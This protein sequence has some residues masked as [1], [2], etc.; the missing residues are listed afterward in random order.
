MLQIKNISKRYGTGAAAQQA[1]DRVSLDLRDSEFVSI[2]GASGSGKT[3]LLN[4][5]GGLGGYDS[6]DI[7][8]D[9]VS[10]KKYKDRDW[11]DYR[12]HRIGFVF[13]SYHLIPHQSVL[14]NVELA[15]TIAGLSHRERKIRAVRALEKVGLADQ[16]H[17]K[18]NQLSGGQMQRVAIARA[19]VNEPSILLADEPTGA[20]DSVTSIQIM[21][22]LKQISDNRLVVM[23]THNPDL[24]E[25]YSTRIIRL[26]D[27]RVLDDSAPFDAAAER[28]RRNANKN[29]ASVQIGRKKAGGGGRKAGMSFL[30]ALSLSF[31]N[32]MNK[33]GR[34]L[35]TAFAG[36]IGIIGI[37][38]VLAVSA[39]INDYID[40]M[41]ESTLKGYPISITESAAETTALQNAVQEGRREK[42]KGEKE[43]VRTDTSS[44]ENKVSQTVVK[45]DL[46]SFKSFLEKKGNGIASAAENIL[47]GYNTVYSVWSQA[48]DGTIVPSNAPT[49]ALIQDPASFGQTFEMGMGAMNF[50]D[51]LNGTASG[52]TNFSEITP[53]ADDRISSDVRKNYEVVYGS[54]PASYDEVVLVLNRRN[55]IDAET[56]YQLGMITGE[57]LQEMSAELRNSQDV[58]IPVRSYEEV[59]SHT[60]TL[61][62]GSREYAENTGITLRIAGLV[63][64]VEDAENPSISTA[65]A[66]TSELTDWLV[67]ETGLSREEPDSIRIYTNS[68]E[69]REKVVDLI[70]QYNDD[71]GEEKQILYTDYA[72]LLTST[73]TSMVDII[74]WILV[75]LMAVSLIVSSI[76][77]A[78]IT[79]ISV[80]ERTK[81]IGIL[82]ALGASKRNISNVFNAETLIIGFCAGVIGILAVL[83]LSHPLTGLAVKMLEIDNIRIFLPLGSAGL[84]VLLSMLI[85]VVAGLV[86]ARRAAKQDPVAALRT[87]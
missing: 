36:S 76:M 54:W 16:I 50:N 18:P 74:T 65:G 51:L 66:Y 30:T 84:L 73:A 7:L 6:G 53:G 21:E 20:L 43:G 86:P 35:M 32:L 28:R 49:L 17:K 26:E 3:T 81:E 55:S 34:T 39:G 8:I 41:Q 22:I 62:P 58:S 10:T 44:L 24:A 71:A 87:E 72:A 27:G 4:I 29:A 56:L 60:F 59:C 23:V 83:L 52:N 14:A 63:K 5:I 46:K 45:N 85:T 78:I 80:I 19:I 1:L 67:N 11:D 61:I 70:D 40:E 75:A 13:Q 9:G 47:Y 12:N 15:L 69:D 25:R 77:I 68:F 2:L 64:P 57:K 79:H 31:R 82:R 37:A 33:K 42:R 38:L 48:S